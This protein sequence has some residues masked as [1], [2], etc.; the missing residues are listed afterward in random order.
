[1]SY[2]ERKRRLKTTFQPREEW[3]SRV[4]ATPIAQLILTVVADW[5]CISPNRLTILSFG[6]TL[7]SGVF[8][9]FD[10]TTDLV[11]AGTILQVAYIIDCMD[12]QLARYRGISSKLGSLLDK[13]S[14]FVKFPFVVVALSI[15]AFNHLPTITPIILG[16]T[17]IFLI[18]Y[19]PYLKSIALKECSVKPWTILS[20]QDFLQRNLR[21]FLFEEAQWYLI[22]SAC[23]FVDKAMVALVMLV[24]TQGIIALFQTGW[25]FWAAMRLEDRRLL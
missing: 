24:V 9:L 13:W 25:V 2:G 18:G 1:M 4:F 6:L 7:L 10:T 17:A 11:I 14:D 8:I 23:L 3:W 12:G 15:Q 21:F 20:G 22:V 16:L 19:Q 5:R